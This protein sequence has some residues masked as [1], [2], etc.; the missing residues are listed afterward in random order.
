[1]L[2]LQAAGITAGQVASG[3][4]LLDDP[5]LARRSFI[6]TVEQPGVGTMTVPGLPLV[7]EPPVLQEPGPAPA[8]GEHNED[9]VRGLL[10]LTEEQYRSLI[11]KEVLV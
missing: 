8:L 9:I 7:V 3:L 1:M 5:Q 2:A 10:G 4:D 11:E 6:R